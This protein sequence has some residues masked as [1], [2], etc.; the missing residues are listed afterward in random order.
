[1]YKCQ[2]EISDH[3]KRIGNDA[4]GGRVPHVAVSAGLQTGLRTNSDECYSVVTNLDDKLDLAEALRNQFGE[5]KI[6]KDWNKCP[7]RKNFIL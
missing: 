4:K 1:M 7:G 5:V 3:D 2:R 6:K